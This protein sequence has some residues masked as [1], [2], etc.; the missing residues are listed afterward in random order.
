MELIV[1]KGALLGTKGVIHFAVP[2]SRW[3]ENIVFT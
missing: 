3:Y 2:A 1:H